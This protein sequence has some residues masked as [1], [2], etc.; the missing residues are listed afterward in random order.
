MTTSTLVVHAAGQHG[1]P[2]L[3]VWAKAGPPALRKTRTHQRRR[4]SDQPQAEDADHG[5]VGENRPARQAPLQSVGAVYVKTT[6]LLLNWAEADGQTVKGSAPVPSVPR[7]I[8]ETLSRAPDRC[9][10]RC[11]QHGARQA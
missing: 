1:P 4:A 5:V 10:G 3:Y 8:R 6:N 9:A 11:H 2:C 7:K